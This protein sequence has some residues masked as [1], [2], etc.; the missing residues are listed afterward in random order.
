MFH[1]LSVRNFILI[2]EL[3][4]EF[5]NGL[6]VITGET[7]AGKSILLDAIL[8]C[9]G[10]KTSSAGI[11]KHGKDYA[12]V[13][14][15]FSLN[16]EIKNFLTQNFIELEE[17]LLIKCVQK[18][19]GRKNFFINNQVVNKAI[20]QQL[21]T[22]LFELHGQN[23]NISLLEI[24][25]QRDIL[26]NF[27]DLLELRMQLAKCYQAW[28][29]IRNEIAEIALKQNSIEQEIDYLNFVTEELIKLNVQTGEEEQLTNIRKDLQNKDKDL[30]LIKDILEHVNNPEINNSISKAEKLLAKQSQNEEFVNISTNLEEAYNNLEE[31]RQNLSNLLENFNKLDYNLEEI[32]ERL[33]AIK[34][35]SRKYNVSADA[36]KT[37]L[38]ESLN[39]LNSLKGKIA[40]QAELQVQE[41]KLST[42]YYK[43]G[44][45]LS[46]KRLV[47]AKRLEE[48]LH[49]ELKQ[50]KMEKATFHVNKAERKEAA[51][52]GIDD[53]VFKASTNPGMSPEAINKIASGGELSR[54]MLALKTSL[55]NKMVKPAIIFDEIDVGIGGEVAD[56]V[57]ERLKKL[58]SATQVIVITHQP[59]VAGKADLHI[60]IEKMQLEKETKVTVK[61]L[62][63]A[64]RQQELARMISGKAITEASLKAAKE[65]LC[66]PVA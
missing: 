46:G 51:A 43:L 32:E 35:I 16:D 10:Y 11:I 36:L 52:Y 8:F 31:A 63:L 12:A 28:Q 54:F 56:K 1:S 14:I 58:S 34:A 7:G 20:M 41:A 38:E 55:F 62:N 42:E 6:C 19:E 66:H 40:N 47:A 23:N 50:L 61:A 18:A 53:I 9:L 17:S 4:I 13:N 60:K 15:V 65:L 45:D 48:V 22:Y 24:N 26:D 37:F 27:G 29:N 21:A 57:G 3:E 49:H 5:T 2:D 25:T 44:K 30:Q 39:Q 59:Q 64:E 33:F